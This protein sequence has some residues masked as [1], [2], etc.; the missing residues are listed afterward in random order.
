MT[1]DGNNFISQVIR[2]IFSSDSISFLI[3][4]SSDIF[5]SIRNQFLGIDKV[6]FE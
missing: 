5:H 4:P 2:E 3:G 6:L 1:I